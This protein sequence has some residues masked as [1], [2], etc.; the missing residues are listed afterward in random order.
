M[1]SSLGLIVCNSGGLYPQLKFS[2]SEIATCDLFWSRLAIDSNNILTTALSSL[3]VADPVTVV[4]SRHI[5]EYLFLVHE[6]YE[7]QL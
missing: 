2:C 5:A 1:P 4:V 7:W 6:L 3:P